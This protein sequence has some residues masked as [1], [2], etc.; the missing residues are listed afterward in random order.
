MA[1]DVALYLWICSTEYSEQP[2]FLRDWRR[3]RMARRSRKVNWSESVKAI[4]DHLRDAFM[5][6]P[7]A[8]GNDSPSYAS[9]VATIVHILA[10]E[11]GWTEEYILNKPLSALFQYLRCIQKSK[12]SDAT[13]MNGISDKVRGEWLRQQNTRN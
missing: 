4:Q 11:Y 7:G 13:F 8:T 5:D 9:W 10:S 2:G 6:A 12:D 3:D 1:A